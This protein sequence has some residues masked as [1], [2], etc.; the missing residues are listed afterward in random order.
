MSIGIFKHVLGETGLERKCRFI[1]GLGILVLVSGSFF[2]YGQTT[3]N[4]LLHETTQTARLMI[5][6]TLMDYHVKTL[7]K[8]NSEPILEM[9]ADVFKPLPGFPNGNAKI[10]SHDRLKEQSRQPADEFER[11]ALDRFQQPRDDRKAG[12]SPVQGM[13]RWAERYTNG[14]KQYQYVQAVYFKPNCLMACHGEDIDD[15]T[16]IPLGNHS[17]RLAPL[18]EQWIQAKTGDL[19]GAVVVTLPMEQAIKAINMN[20]AALITAAL[21]TSI[22]A[23]LLSSVFIRYMIV[24]SVEHFA[25]SSLSR[26]P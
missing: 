10:I 15:G 17:K 19:A 11:A 25:P 3:E 20:R 14:K 18:G 24:K 16:E 22:A 1:C 6:L 5:D 21:I 9:L 4:L 12:H 2:W 23:I 26:R 13:P 8:A 7:G